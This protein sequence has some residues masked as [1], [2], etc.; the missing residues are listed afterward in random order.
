MPKIQTLSKIKEGD[1]KETINSAIAEGRHVDYLRAVLENYEWY[2]KEFADV[3]T[4]NGELS[5]VYIF[6]VAYERKLKLWREIEILGS[7]TFEKLAK[8]IVAGM[9]WHYDHMHGFTIPGIEKKP[10]GKLEF[11]PTTRLD[12]FESHWED[13][14]FPTYKSNEIKIC[15][16]DY[17]KHPIFDFIFDFGDGHEFEIIYKGKR[18]LKP[19]EK[20]TAFPII[21]NQQGVAPK[22][23]PPCE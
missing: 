6:R 17:S 22:Q 5:A 15:Q 8:I 12:F 21:I 13:D 10:S 19:S 16:I 2:K 11:E 1:F 7:Q 4:N 14:P 18:V 20:V 3:F 9:K 23:Y